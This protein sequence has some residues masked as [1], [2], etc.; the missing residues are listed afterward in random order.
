MCQLANISGN[1]TNHSLRA[2]GA[3]TLFEKGISEKIIQERTGHR[4]L[5]ALRIY[6]HT[7]TAQHQAVSN[8]LPAGTMQP[9]P[10]SSY[11]TLNAQPDISRSSHISTSRVVL[12]L[13]INNLLTLTKVRYNTFG[14]RWSPLLLELQADNYHYC[15]SSHASNN[16][17]PHPLY[18]ALQ[19]DT[20]R[21]NLEPWDVYL[22]WR[23]ANEVSLLTLVRPWPDWPE[24]F[25]C[26]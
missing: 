23:G 5:E 24:W 18:G 16:N 7:N 12:F 17:Q 2:T 13:A 20:P 1:K 11:P 6:E 26:P 10:V 25:R 19:L 15:L 3:T 14:I 4:S 8:I 9:H 21:I 22:M